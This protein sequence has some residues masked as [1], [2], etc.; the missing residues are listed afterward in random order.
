M[1]ELRFLIRRLQLVWRWDKGTFLY[2]KVWEEEDR[3]AH[4]SREQV[5][6]EALRLIMSSIARDIEMQEDFP[7]GELPTLEC[8]VRLGK[9]REVF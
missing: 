3:K 8:Q 9:V 7:S 1:Y 5:T 6:E 4:R 2:N